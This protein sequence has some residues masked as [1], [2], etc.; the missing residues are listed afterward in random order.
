MLNAVFISFFILGVFTPLFAE[1]SFPIS[2]VGNLQPFF[3][4]I[5]GVLLFY[6]ILW[7]PEQKRRKA[8]EALRADLKEGDK[9]TAIGIIGTV[10]ESGKDTTV[11]QMVDGSKIE[12]LTA[13]ITDVHPAGE[14][15]LL[16]PDDDDAEIE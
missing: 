5:L 3:V 11:L 7:R 15:E 14:K 10:V 2:D 12:V 16:M 9:V 8:L 1:D 6:F 13:A 4:I